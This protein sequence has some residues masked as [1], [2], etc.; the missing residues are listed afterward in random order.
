MVIKG[1]DMEEKEVVDLEEFFELVNRPIKIQSETLGQLNFR[2]ILVEDDIFIKNCLKDNLEAELFCKQFLINQITDPVLTLN[3]LDE[4]SEEEICCILKEYLKIEMFDE[5][6]NFNSSKN[7][8]TIFKEGMLR[9]KAYIT[10]LIQP[11]IDSFILSNSVAFSGLY[12]LANTLQW[13]KQA[14]TPWQNWIDINNNVI[15]ATKNITGYWDKFQED[16]QISP[17]LAQKYLKKHHWFI[18]PNMDYDIAYNIVEVCDSSS[19]HERKEI[20]KIFINYFLDNNCENLDM[21]INKWSD[22]PL[23][24]E[25]MKIIKD[26]INVIKNN[27][28]KNVNYSN[29][30]IP[31]LIS[32]IDGI[33][34]K[35]MEINGL[36]FKYGKI[37]YL[38]N[39]KEKKDDD[40]NTMNMHSY[41]RQFTENNEFYDAMNDVFLDLLFQN[42][43]PGEKCSFIQF[44]RHKILHGENTNYGKKE[45]MIRCF[46]ILDFLSEL[47]F[48]EDTQKK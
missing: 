34:N 1:D 6:F 15:Q 10:S 21:L 36:T 35:F 17:E 13:V 4:V 8:Y 9:Y 25:R 32:Q 33:Q 18:S 7:I 24:N 20:N 44:N 45:Y 39:E 23:F 26:C 16:Y 42:V 29:L 47:M 19:K 38:D 46:M 48:I 37:Y 3:E 30:V 41:F 22:N 14:I 2:H 40:G 11:V 43:H 27:A 12:S 28:N 31:T 5:Y